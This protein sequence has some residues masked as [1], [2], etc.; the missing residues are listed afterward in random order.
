LS[1]GIKSK[2]KTEKSGGIYYRHILHWDGIT[3]FIHH[4][5]TGRTVQPIRVKH[6]AE[7]LLT[8][9]LFAAHAHVLE[10]LSLLGFEKTDEKISRVDA[11]VMLDVSVSEFVCLIL[12]GHLVT[13]FRKDNTY[14]LLCA[15]PSY[16][17]Y[18]SK[19]RV[20][21]C[22]YP[23]TSATG[24]RSTVAFVIGLRVVSL[25]ASNR[26]FNRNRR[27]PF[28]TEPDAF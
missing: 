20:E 17:T 23:K 2:S 8:N 21:V 1:A 9:S 6:G 16:V 26:N 3:L 27:N 7:V 22:I 24:I 11:Q 19:K 15:K 4:N 10:F 25:T 14:D 12:E 18:G 13:K 28:E 5:P